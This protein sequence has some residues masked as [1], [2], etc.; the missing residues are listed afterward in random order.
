MNIK[1]IK[2][3]IL[4]WWGLLLI[5][6]AQQI[7]YVPGETCAI[8]DMVQPI[9]KQN[10]QIDPTWDIRCGSMVKGYDGKYH[11]YYSRWPRQTGHEAWISHSEV[12][13]AVS[14]KPE[15][16]Y[17][18]INVALAS[19][20]E[21]YWDGATSHNPYMVMK[22]GKYYLYYVGT[23]GKVLSTDQKI[24]PYGDEWWARRNTQRIGVA[25]SESPAGP[26]KHLDVPVLSVSED[27]AAFDA[28]CVTNPAICVGRDGKMVMLYKAVCKNGTRGGGK[29]RF[30]VAFADSPTGPFVKTNKLIFQPEDPNANMVAEDPYIWYDDKLDK[31]YAIVR[32]V[33]QLFT[34]ED[35]GMLALMESDDAMNWRPAKYPKVLPVKLQWEDGTVY[36]AKADHVERPFL[37]RD[38]A[39]VPKLLFGAF[40]IHTN[41]VHREHSFNGRIPLR[42]PENK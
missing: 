41:G 29:V 37:Y 33:I 39:G 34:G 6:C 14:D 28:L 23:Q 27:T 22:D 20:G 1:Q 11:L 40:S 38:E 32:D 42:L 15:G 7:Q 24:Q 4:G 12:A 30:S 21:K 36:D 2:Y 13:Y 18:F 31:Y 25:V 8:A 5:S 3:I 26:W 35:S 19:R 10:V 16:P 17:R 9:P